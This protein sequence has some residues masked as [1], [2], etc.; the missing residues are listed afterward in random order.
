MT[1][2][3]APE[4]DFPVRRPRLALH[5]AAEAAGNRL[6]RRQ[7]VV[8]LVTEDADEALP[9][10]ALLVAQRLAHVGQHHQV[11]GEPALPERG[12]PHLPA[13][14]RAGQGNRLDARSA[15]IEPLIHLE[16]GR[17][18]I[19]QPLGRRPEQALAGVVHQLQPPALVEGEDGDVDL[20][21]DLAQQ[22]RRFERVEALPAQHLG[23][24]VDLGVQVVERIGAPRAARADR[25]VAF[26]Q[27]RQQV[28]DGLQRHDHARPHRREEAGGEDR[29]RDRQ[30]PLRARMV[31]AGPEEDEGEGGARREGTERE[32]DEPL[33][34]GEA[35]PGRRHRP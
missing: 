29:Q 11:M 34:V 6:D 32:Q 35:R 30:R 1:P 13:S 4:I 12:V 14:G 20:R 24:R 23:E 9:R 10:G 33:I 15:G 7:R 25:E 18:S 3:P 8:Q 21:H 22:R 26:P 16:L 27:R 2:R 19:E 31:I 28:G 17:M 5:Q